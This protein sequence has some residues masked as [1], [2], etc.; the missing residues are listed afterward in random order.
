MILKR[1]SILFFLILFVCNS[2]FAEGNANNSAIRDLLVLSPNMISTLQE[3]QVLYKNAFMKRHN[4]IVALFSPAGGKFILYRKG[5]LPLEAPLVPQHQNYELATIIEHAAM[6]PYLLSVLDRYNP[7]KKSDYMSQMRDLQKKITQASNDVNNLPVTPNEKKLF[8]SILNLSNQYI[9]VTI[10]RNVFL[11][12]TSDEY[13]RNLKPYL[14]ELTQTIANDQ[15]GHWMSVIRDWKLMLGSDWQNT[16]AVIVYI[17]TKPKNNIFLDI[18]I[19][20]MGKKAVGNQLY[21]FTTIS[22]IPTADEALNLL[23]REL[24]DQQLASQIYGD[25]FLKYSQ[26]LGIAARK[27][28]LQSCSR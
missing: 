2:A 16:Y 10:E 21:Y 8:H 17:N 13:A 9:N 12:N 7:L 22:Y 4:I 23:A 28:M 6:E 18:L 24:P 11:K 26:I 25:Y 20:F 5:K 3:Q 14:V 1:K 27:A 15:V 19:H